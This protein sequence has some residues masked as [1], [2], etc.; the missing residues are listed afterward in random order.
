MG[1]WSGGQGRK[2][3]DHERA[4]LRLPGLDLDAQH[5]ATRALRGRMLRQEVYA[6]I[7][8][9]RPVWRCSGRD[10]ILSVGPEE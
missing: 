8:S 7:R 5:E 2:A 4:G 10:G 1:P 3:Q 6:G 9:I